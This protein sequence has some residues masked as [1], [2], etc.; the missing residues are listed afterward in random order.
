MPYVIRTTK[1]GKTIE[2]E[3]YYTSRYGKKG[4]KRKDRVKPTKEEQKK[5]N[6]KNT[7]K[8]LRILLNANFKGGDY[9]VILGYKKEERPK[10]VEEMRKDIDK[11]L[12]LLRNEYRKQ[13]MVLKYIHVMEVGKRGARHHHLVI[14]QIDPRIISK[15]W[16]KGRVQF[17]PLDDSGQYR[18]LAE[19]LTKNA[20]SSDAIQKKAYNSSKNLYRPEPEYTI[21][22]HRD[23]FRAEARPIK[24]YYVDKDTVQKGIHSPEY[25][26]LGFFR[27]TLIKIPEHTKLKRI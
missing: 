22:T 20:K 11:F 17:F 18:L 5:I 9:H 4:M 10:T 15:C 7:I 23:F 8:N 6:L 27:Y 16:E 26:A 1:A 13:G 3:K 24:G 25:G 14:N 19:Y 21:V 2:I 12:R